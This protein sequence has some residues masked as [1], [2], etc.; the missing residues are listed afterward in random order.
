MGMNEEKKQP[1]NDADDDWEDRKNVDG[2]PIYD[3]NDDEQAKT[4][5]LN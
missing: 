2:L 4:K 1:K 5:N 3:E